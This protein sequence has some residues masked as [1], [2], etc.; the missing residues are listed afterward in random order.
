VERYKLF[1]DGDWCDLVSNEWFESTEPFSGKAYAP[2]LPATQ[3]IMLTDLFYWDMKDESRAFA[4]RFFEKRKAMPTFYQAGVYCAVAHY[5]KAIKAAGTDA[6]PAVMARMKATLV[7]DFMTKDGT[8]R[9]DGRVIRDMHLFQV[10][11]PAASK[12]PWDYYKLVRT[13][14]REKAYRPLSESDCPLVKKM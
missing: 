8:V 3:G 5:R 1:I 6:T 14:R 10:K 2:G 13:I 11:T 4:K 7:N 9:E 12:G